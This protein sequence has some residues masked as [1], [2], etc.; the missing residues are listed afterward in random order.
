M[1][2][3]WDLLIQRTPFNMIFR[4]TLPLSQPDFLQTTEGV[5]H[6]CSPYLSL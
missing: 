5:I 4:L 6:S 1:G 3:C 2:L